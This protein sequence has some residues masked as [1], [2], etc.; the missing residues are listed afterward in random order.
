[1]DDFNFAINS[2]SVLEK[3]LSTHLSTGKIVSTAAGNL[4]IN[5]HPLSYLYNPVTDEITDYKV[6]EKISIQR[7]SHDLCFNGNVNGGEKS[8]LYDEN[9]QVHPDMED[10]MRVSVQ[11]VIY[12]D[13]C[14][15][16]SDLYYQLIKKIQPRSL[17]PVIS[18][19]TLSGSDNIKSSPV[20]CG[21]F[22]G[23]EVEVT[24]SSCLSRTLEL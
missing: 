6:Y 18:N 2:K 9:N 23:S 11:D 15:Q 13:S 19:P 3:M 12:P 16:I 7:L 24:S 5:H 10:N 4:L 22:A 20:S 1:M 14:F 17:I 8:W 21:F